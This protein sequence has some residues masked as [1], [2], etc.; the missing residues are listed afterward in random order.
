MLLAP[1]YFLPFN[2]NFRVSWS[3][4]AKTLLNL[5][6]IPLTL[7]NNL[8]KNWHF[9]NVSPYTLID[10]IPLSDLPLWLQWNYVIFTIWFFLEPIELNSSPRTSVFVLLYVEFDCLLVILINIQLLAELCSSNGWTGNFQVFYIDMYISKWCQFFSK[11]P[12]L[13]YSISF[14]IILHH[15][16]LYIVLIKAVI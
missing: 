3:R 7:W 4:L 16:I 8:G 9:Y 10:Y 14:P 5:F 2:M 1:L 12:L 13:K 6:E 11:T 15:I